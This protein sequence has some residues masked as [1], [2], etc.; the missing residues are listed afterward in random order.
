MATVRL[1][2]PLERL[3]KYLAIDMNFGKHAEESARLGLAR[4]EHQTWFN[5][6]AS[7]IAGPHD[8]IVPE[9]TEKLDYEVEL[10]VVIGKRAKNM[11]AEDA[12]RHVF[13]YLVANDVSA[14]D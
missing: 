3:G 2:A 4:A 13:E 8:A 6:R 10:G 12:E 1:L 7:C 14:R 9:P 11:A 5:K